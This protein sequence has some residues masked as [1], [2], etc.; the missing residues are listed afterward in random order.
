MPFDMILEKNEILTGMY[1]ISDGI[2]EE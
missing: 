2:I 1:F